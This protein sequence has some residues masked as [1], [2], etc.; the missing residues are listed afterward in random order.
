LAARDRQCDRGAGVLP[1]GLSL[2]SIVVG[3][4]LFTGWKGGEM[5][6]RHRVAVYAEPRA[7]G[8]RCKELI[9]CPSPRV[10]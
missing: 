2:A 6:F 7:H 4:A 8:Q 3:I 5:V 1:H 9:S 10:V